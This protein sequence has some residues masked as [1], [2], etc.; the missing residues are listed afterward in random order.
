MNYKE[1]LDFI[2]NLGWIET[3]EWANRTFYGFPCGRKTF[4]QLVEHNG[5]WSISKGDDF[6]YIESPT[7]EEIEK[8]TEL[9]KNYIVVITDSETHT[10][11]ELMDATK[12]LRDFYNEYDQENEEFDL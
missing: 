11:K 2:K 9:V 12:A 4:G 5:N 1:K 10:V 8:Y 6:Y 7:D 3:G